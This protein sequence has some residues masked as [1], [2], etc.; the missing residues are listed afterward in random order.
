MKKKKKKKGAII[1]LLLPNI[2]PKRAKTTKKTSVGC[3]FFPQLS[4]WDCFCF[5]FFLII[6]IIFIYFFLYLIG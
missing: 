6:I 2:T 4:V 5:F 1:T 3:A